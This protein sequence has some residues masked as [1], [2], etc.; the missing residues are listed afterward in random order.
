MDSA[1]DHDH[2]HNAAVPES[3][4]P[5]AIMERL[6]GLPEHLQGH[7]RRFIL[8]AVSPE[9]RAP[10]ETYYRQTDEAEKAAQAWGDAYGAAGFYSASGRSWG[11]EGSSVFCFSFET[12]KAPTGN[13]WTKAGRGFISRPGYVAMYPSKRPAGKAITAEL[14]A[15]PK[16]PGYG[17]AL[18]HL[19]HITDLNTEKGSSGV[20]HS[21]GKLHFTVPAQI[22]DRYFASVVNHNYDIAEKAQRASEYLAGENPEWAPSLDFKDDPIAWRPPEGWVFRTKSEFEFIIAE[23]RLAAERA[24]AVGTSEPAGSGEAVAT[25]QTPGGDND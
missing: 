6:H 21:D 16:F 17:V 13:A 1:R 24:K 3:P 22:G 2:T 14:A 7:H 10:F 20:G 12:A 5:L 23:A 25:G 4:A 9:V 15:L 18:D 19:G 11:T 8:E